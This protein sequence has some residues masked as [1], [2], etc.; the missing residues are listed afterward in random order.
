MLQ[1]VST[2]MELD[3]GE[4]LRT[5]AASHAVVKLMDNSVVEAGERAEFRV[6]AARRDTTIHLQRGAVIVQAAKRGSGH[7][8]VL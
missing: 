7:L 3:D 2:G 8:Y 4:V 6:S 5:A 1:P